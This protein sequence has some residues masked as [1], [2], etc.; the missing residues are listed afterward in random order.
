MIKV[1]SRR[2]TLPWC[3]IGDFNDMLEE[4]N[5]KGL[6]KHPRALLDGFKNT[7]EE[8]NLTELDL[9]G[10]S[11][12]W[13][14]SRGKEDWVREQID[15]AFASQSW[16]QKFPLCK[17]NVSHNIYSDHDPL[18]LE[19]YSTNYSKKQFRLKIHG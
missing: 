15:R 12:T 3:I 5:K 8:C 14:K 17:L 13:E 6:H 2:D 18:Q 19:L 11:F 4:A 9:M 7:I 10:G 1:L 16:W